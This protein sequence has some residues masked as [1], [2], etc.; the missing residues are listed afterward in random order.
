MIA[1]REGQNFG[2][3]NGGRTDI[4]KELQSVSQEDIARLAAAGVEGSF[5][6][7]WVALYGVLIVCQ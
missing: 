1:P 5:E 6:S 2:S 4:T 7:N 3:L